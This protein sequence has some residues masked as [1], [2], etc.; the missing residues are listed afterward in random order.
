MKR[1]LLLLV[2]ALVL[3]PAVLMNRP[4]LQA[5]RPAQNQMPLNL[6][7]KWTTSDGD[8]VMVEHR[9]QSV[10]ATFISGAVCPNGGTRSYYI[11]GLMERKIIKMKNVEWNNLAPCSLLSSRGLA[12]ALMTLAMLCPRL[13]RR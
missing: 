10:R 4:T 1:L 13:I 9:G 2:T 7:G 8:Q 11:N 6:N 3:S 5:A 12:Q